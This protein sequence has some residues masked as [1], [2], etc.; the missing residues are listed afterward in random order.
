MTREVNFRSLLAGYADLSA[1]VDSRIALNAAPQGSPM[2]LVAFVAR[3]EREYTLD[4]TLANEATFF[5]VQCWAP[6]SLEAS[7]VADE[8]EAALL[9]ETP[10]RGLVTARSTGYDQELDLHADVLTVEWDE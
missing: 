2:P 6:T 8:V 3:H 5:D 1:L 7:E 4:N 9:S 10:Q